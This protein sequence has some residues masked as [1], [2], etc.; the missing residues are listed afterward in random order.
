[1]RGC[2]ILVALAV[3]APCVAQWASPPFQPDS[4]QL[5]AADLKEIL[6]LLCPGQE[7]AGADSACHVCPQ[8]TKAAG[9]KTDSSIESAVRGHFLKPDSDDVLV[10]L[11]GCAPRADNFRDAILFTRS[12]SG[13]FVNPA[14]GFPAGQCRKVMGRGGLDGLLCFSASPADDRQSAALTFGYAGSEPRVEL[15]KAFDNTGGACDAPKRVVVQSA[16]R[17]VK[18]APA[19]NGKWTLRI[20]ANCRRGSLSA[21]SLKACGRGAGFEDIGPAGLF[22]G[23]RVDYLFD[24]AAFSLAPASKAIKQAYDV[25]SA[26]VK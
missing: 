1:M 4:S 13:W 24:G 11:Y 8:Q 2:L 3:S 10:V 16:M 7:S 5:G 22:H 15:L 20:T 14:A 6:G 18:L 19:P 12:R 23:F 26:E 25:C 9:M 21:A 17:E